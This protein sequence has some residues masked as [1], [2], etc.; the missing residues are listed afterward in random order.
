MSSASL[1]IW[2]GSRDRRPHLAVS[3]L[4]ALVARECQAIAA[5]S[6][7]GNTLVLP[8]PPL[9]DCAALELAPLPLQESI[10]RFARLAQAQGWQRVQICPLFLL[11]GIHVSEDIPAEVAAAR[12]RLRGEIEL[13]LLPHLGSRREMVQLLAAAFSRIRAR[14]RIILA[15]GSRRESAQHKVEEMAIELNALPAYW[16]VLPDLET[17][18]SHLVTGGQKNIAIQPYFL[19][20]GGITDAIA[21]E[22]RRLQSKFTDTDL[23]LGQPLGATPEL[24]RLIRDWIDS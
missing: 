7:L 14:G 19:F 20:T 11:N 1:L 13:E 9:I 23:F 4:T 8:K 21:R 6:A 2:H 12:S 16:K 22:V 24:A 10:L 15:H 17:Q 5:S 18:I 3:R